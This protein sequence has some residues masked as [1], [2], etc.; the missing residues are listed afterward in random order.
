MT[1]EH[2]YDLGEGTLAVAAER[3]DLLD[4]FEH[5]LG[6]RRL[7]K[8][9]AP[10]VVVSIR[11]GVPAPPPPQA[12][13]LY[14]GP[15]LEEGECLFARSGETYFMAF[16]GEAS[17][18]ITPLSGRAE[19]IVSPAHPRRATGS[20]AA[21]AIEFAYDHSG[22]QLL[23]AAGLALPEQGGMILVSAPS[24]TGKTT[25]ALALARC[26]FALAADDVVALRR[27]GTR[28]M[29]RGLPR[30]LNVH[31]KTL[32]MLP[33]IPVGGDWRDNGEQSLSWRQLTGTVALENRELPVSRLVLLRRGSVSTVEPVAATDALVALAADNVRGSLAGLTPL[34]SRR[35]AMLAEMAREVP[36]CCVQL[37]SGLAGLETIAEELKSDLAD[38]GISSRRR[39]G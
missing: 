31:R 38:Q 3:R 23:H 4:G 26:G 29:A 18:E 8:P 11:V 24:G 9:A 25:T 30:A 16:P 10:T 27:E 28:L 34:Q 20:M 22:Q 36:A 33:W 39:K 13:T 17:L 15:L 2:G 35:F 7:G 1:I 12:E 21:I 14:S 37:A 19:M 5:F 6:G 32:D